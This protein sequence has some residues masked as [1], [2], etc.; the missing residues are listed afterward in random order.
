MPYIGF[1][2]VINCKYCF[3]WQWF[4]IYGLKDRPVTRNQ[5][6]KVNFLLWCFGLLSID[7]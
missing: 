3:C 6:E 2:W 4:C 5:K 7:G 1:F